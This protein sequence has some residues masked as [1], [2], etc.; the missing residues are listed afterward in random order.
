MAD[1]HTG[2]MIARSSNYLGILKLHQVTGDTLLLHTNAFNRFEVLQCESGT[3]RMKLRLCVTGHFIRHITCL[4]EFGIIIYHEERTLY[5]ASLSDGSIL[6]K[7][8][9]LF[10]SEVH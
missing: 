10:H 4:P 7:V 5:V 3:A 1:I 2:E 8:C 6:W 9:T